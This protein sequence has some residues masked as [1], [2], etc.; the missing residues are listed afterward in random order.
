MR[1]NLRAIGKGITDGLSKVNSF[2]KKSTTA[3]P[4]PGGGA[5]SAFY[6]P[7]QSV[8][9]T[10][11]QLNP[12]NDPAGAVSQTTQRIIQDSFDSISKSGWLSRKAEAE[13]EWWT[14]VATMPAANLFTG[15]VNTLY[16]SNAHTANWLLANVFESANG[17][18]RGSY[19]AGAGRE[20]YHR[21]M[22]G[23]ISRGVPEAVEDWAKRNEQTIAGSGFGVSQAGLAAF[24]REV[25]LAMNDLNMGR[26]VDRDPAVLRARDS[27]GAA[28]KEAMEIGKGKAGQIAV[29]GFEEIKDKPAYTPFVWDGGKMLKLIKQGTVDRDQIVQGLSQAY[30]TAGQVQTRDAQKIA[31]AVVSRAISRDSDVNMS[32]G[33][34]M[35][36]DGRDFLLKSLVSSGVGTKEANAILRRFTGEAAEKGKLS[37]AK[38]RNE[39]DLDVNI[40]T[41]DG[42][43]IRIVDMLNNDLHGTW[44]RYTRRMAGSAALARVGLNNRTKVED[45]ITAIRT[46]QRSIGEE[47]MDADMLRAM[48]SEFDGGPTHGYSNGVINQGIQPELGL[49][50][51]VTNL[52]LLGKLGMSQLAETG[53][54][55]AQLG[56]ENW[57]TRGPAAAFD[58]ALKQGNKE[59]LDDAAYL[60]GDIGQDHMNFAP[61]LD[62]DE[63]SMRDKGTIVQGI[64]RFTGNLQ[65]IQNYVSGFNHVR[66]YQQQ[67]AVMGSMDKVFR[68]MKK[69]IDAD[70][71][72]LWRNTIDKPL[73]RRLEQDLGLFPEQLDKIAELITNGTVEFKDY[74]GHTLVN[75]LNANKWDDPEFEEAFA[76][77][78]VRNL[79]QAVQ[80]PMPGE[81]DVWMNTTLGSMLTHLRTF[82]MLS[83]QK[84]FL[85]NMRHMDQQTTN[86][87]LYGT[88]VAGMVIAVRDAID[89]KERTAADHAK[90]AVA[91][92]SMTGWV[93]SAI[94]PVM[95]SL[96]FEDMRFNQFGPVPDYSPPVWS[97]VNK[98]SRLPGAAMD[99][100]T[101]QGD[102]YDTQ[103][104][105]A[106]PFA[107][108]LGLARIFDELN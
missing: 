101:G 90:Q 48:F 108:T 91:Y 64:S 24:N 58:K 16:K 41:N 65:N 27:Y 88:A 28:A 31:E 104:L 95:A 34:L 10:T 67:I 78:I 102:W 105:K 44:Q 29:D 99:T 80:S 47:P 59:L 40:K 22:F 107:N 60:L 94:D 32:M 85:R 14:K 17:L 74:K 30:I 35:T 45:L 57:W 63:M 83:I 49:L 73:L 37:F 38:R 87:F 61:H 42:S 19:T 50:K 12:L 25:M 84:Q 11:F 89:G 79:N 46:E 55:I 68:S 96:G 66:M 54:T 2:R 23:H 75:R 71:N 81:K 62:L 56:F 92:A 51:R 15:N 7:P 36:G 21:R 69:A 9:T 100:V 52:S 103:S 3:G 18:G 70:P 106:L 53:S 77:A 76:S 93:P 4:T 20:S 39:I 5:S 86:M 43:D 82:P 8:S 72:G 26:A 98:A 13:Q 33:Y 97:W 1:L 6:P